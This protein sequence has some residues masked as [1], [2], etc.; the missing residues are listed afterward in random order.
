MKDWLFYPL[1]ILTVFAMIFFAL[2]FGEST[3]GFDVSKGWVIEGE[4]LQELTVSPGAK[5]EIATNLVNPEM[6]AVMSSFVELQNARSAGIFTSIPPR[7]Q[8]EFFG[9]PLLFSIEAKAGSNNPVGTFNAAFFSQ[10][11]ASRWREF[12][13]SNEFETYTFI[14]TP[15]DLDIADRYAYFGIWP[16]AKGEDRTLAV[17]KMSIKRVNPVSQS[18]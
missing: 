16:D 8:M 5:L 1:S 6:H 7:F 10:K 17:R 2:S 11:T 12:E 9:Y 18:D 15:K 3:S 14:F 4:A 13:V